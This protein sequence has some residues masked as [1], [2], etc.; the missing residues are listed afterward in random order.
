MPEDKFEALINGQK[1]PRG[2]LAEMF[3]ELTETA[4]P[5]KGEEDARV[6]E[7]GIGAKISLYACRSPQHFQRPASSHLSKNTPRL[8]S[9][10]PAD[11]A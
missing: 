1:I 5:T 6:Q 9:I 3:D 8:Q 10:R 11:V 2:R 7:R 4:N